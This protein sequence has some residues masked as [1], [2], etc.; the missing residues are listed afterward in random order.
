MDLLLSNFVEPHYHAVTPECPVR[1]A[2]RLMHDRQSTYVVVEEQGEPL[3]ILTE[4][5]AV[6]LLLESF[7]GNSWSELPVRHVMTS[8]V[9]AVSD[10]MTL[11]EALAI[12]RGGR[13]RHLPVLNSAGKLC[14]V[15]NQGRM[16]NTLYQHARDYVY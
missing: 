2:I 15:L 12:A 13:I 4:R 3:G 7:E 8:P 11:M 9:V 5:D 1:D 14:G 10:D 16:L 6:G